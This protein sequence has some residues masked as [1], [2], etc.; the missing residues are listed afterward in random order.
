MNDE[1]PFAVGFSPSLTRW[2][3]AGPY[4]NATPGA[5][6]ASTRLFAWGILAGFAV[7]V[8]ALVWFAGGWPI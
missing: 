1:L 2:V 4:T 5:L 3:V 7:G 6:D 8:A